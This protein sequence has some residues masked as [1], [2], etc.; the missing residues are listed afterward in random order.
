MLNADTHGDAE[1]LARLW[2]AFGKQSVTTSDG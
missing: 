1:A 2:A